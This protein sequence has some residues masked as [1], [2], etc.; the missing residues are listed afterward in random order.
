MVISRAFA[1]YVLAKQAWRPIVG[2]A[3][4]LLSFGWMMRDYYEVKVR[5]DSLSEKIVRLEQ[6]G[7]GGKKL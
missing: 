1:L 2:I 5:V 3:M 7:G 4:C 6:A